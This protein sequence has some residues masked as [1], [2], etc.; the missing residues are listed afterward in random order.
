M[1]DIGQICYKYFNRN[2]SIFFITWKTFKVAL[3]KHFYV[4]V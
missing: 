1:N 4:D 3:Q 2:C